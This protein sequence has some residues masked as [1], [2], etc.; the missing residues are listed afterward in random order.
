MFACWLSLV[1]LWAGESPP[2]APQRAASAATPRTQPSLDALIEQLGDFRFPV[3]LEATSQLSELSPHDL[4]GLVRRYREEPRYEHKLRLRLVIERL[5]YRKLMQG[6][7]GFLGIS[8]TIL[9]GVFD[10]QTG[11][12]VECIMAHQVHAGHAADR[13]GM[14]PGDLILSFDGQPVSK[15]MN[16]S[17]PPERPDPPP[18]RVM[19]LEPRIESF[20]TQVK[21][22][23]PGSRTPIRILRTGP[24]RQI[25]VPVTAPVEAM[26][27][28]LALAPTIIPGPRRAN[29][30][31][32]VSTANGL[33]VTQVAPGS[34]LANAQVR[35]GDV[36][37]AID[38]S[39][40]QSGMGADALLQVFRTA[41]PGRQVLL[42]LRPL[43]QVDLV[44]TL[45]ARPPDMMNVNDW[46]AAQA[47]F[48][49]WWKEKTGGV[50]V[51][52]R[53]TTPSGLTSAPPLPG[54]EAGLVP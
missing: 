9:S 33:L 12:P 50:S 10:P 17:P 14:Q 37:C 24:P 6:Q 7:T 32:F 23:E 40:V 27:L 25:H 47:R 1:L 52:I 51:R 45:G 13:G 49:S 46:M 2:D 38:N 26:G 19:M 34:W 21:I 15:L 4:D 44:V 16:L 5:Y 28:N 29:G 39:A 31:A 42:D 41:G 48:A 11:Q 36:I 8:P 30:P 22:R 53:R 54:P 18:G 3:R 43:E 35:A 20:T